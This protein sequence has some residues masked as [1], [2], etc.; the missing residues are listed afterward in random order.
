[1]YYP[2]PYVEIA[3]SRPGQEHDQHAPCGAGR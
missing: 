2:R 1:L 3:R